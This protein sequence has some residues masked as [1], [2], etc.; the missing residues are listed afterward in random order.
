MTEQTDLRGAPIEF[1]RVAGEVAAGAEPS[2][3]DADGKALRCP[4]CRS[5]WWST[6]DTR[7]TEPAA[8]HRVRCK[9]EFGRGCRWRGVRAQ[10]TYRTPEPTGDSEAADLRGLR[11]Q[12][13]DRLWLARR[14]SDGG[15]WV[16]AGTLEEV[17]A[18]LGRLE[19]L[20]AGEVD[21]DRP[22]QC[23]A[24]HES[25]GWC[26]LR[27]EGHDGPHAH[28]LR[29]STPTPAPQQGGAG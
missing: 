15:A 13:R 7:V 22:T 11:T 8:A 29:W 26:C 6:T 3:I 18:A 4:K 20:E 10:M 25:G 23:R 12:L 28:N 21:H 19:A 16:S 24:V 17:L 9:D 5:S 2:L 27:E 1:G 14:E